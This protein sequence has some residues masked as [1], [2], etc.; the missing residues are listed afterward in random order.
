MFNNE[1]ETVTTPFTWED[2]HQRHWNEVTARSEAEWNKEY[3]EYI[4]N[5]GYNRNPDFASNKHRIALANKMLELEQDGNTL[6]HLT[7]TY[8][9]YQDNQYSEQEVNEFFTNFYRRT[10]LPNLL[11]ACNINTWKKKLLQP[12]CYCF[13]DEHEHKARPKLIRNNFTNEL[14]Q[15]YIYPIKLHH[16]AILS[17]P[18][19]TLLKMQSFVGVSNMPRNKWTNKVMTFDIKQCESTRIL[20]A[21]KMLHKYPEFLSFTPIKHIKSIN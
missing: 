1:Y 20:Y 8:K 5:N 13:L 21:S 6:F 3:I 16:H 9:P 17:V 4:Q 15:T 12:E 11:D 2:K 7:V 19:D 14:E 18:P 10:L